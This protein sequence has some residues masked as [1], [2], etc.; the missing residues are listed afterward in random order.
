MRKYVDTEV[1]GVDGRWSDSMGKT[2]QTI[3]DDWNT[4]LAVVNSNIQKS[5]KK[6]MESV[7]KRFTSL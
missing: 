3:L 4:K 7:E 5:N 1:Q 2:I 6:V